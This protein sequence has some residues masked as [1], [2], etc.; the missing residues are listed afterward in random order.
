M[1][2]FEPAASS[3]EVNVEAPQCEQLS[4]SAASGPLTLATACASETSVLNS[5]A[6]FPDGV[7]VRC[8]F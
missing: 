6:L 2:S 1:R 4:T 7:V 8:V 5:I 3:E